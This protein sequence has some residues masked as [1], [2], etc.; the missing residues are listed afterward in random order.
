MGLPGVVA[1]N[2]IPLPA[3]GQERQAPCQIR[4]L[5][6]DIQWGR[7]MSRPARPFCDY[8][9]KK[10]KIIKK[11]A[12]ISDFPASKITEVRKMID[13]TTEHSTLARQAGDFKGYRELIE[14]PAVSLLR[15]VI[16]R[17]NRKWSE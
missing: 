14:G 7:T 1:A 16:P 8:L 11:H 17:R 3:F 10:E 12:G 6:P 13:L 9:V 2:L 4:R 5:W 15:S